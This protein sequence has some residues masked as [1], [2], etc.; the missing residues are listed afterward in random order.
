MANSYIPA[1][2]RI[3]R[4][5]LHCPVPTAIEVAVKC[6]SRYRVQRGPFKG[7]IFHSPTLPMLLGTY[8]METCQAI[9]H[10]RDFAVRRVINIGAAAGFYAIG[11]ARLFPNST[12]H[13]FEM[14]AG[15]AEMM[16]QNAARNSVQDRIISRG[17][18]TVMDL[19]QLTAPAGLSLVVIDVEG[20]E[21]DLL[22]PA[23]AP[24]LEESLVFVEL[25]DI[26]FEGCA[27]TIRARFSGTHEIHEFFTKDRNLGDF[28]FFWMTVPPLA[29]I[30]RYRRALLDCMGES[31]PGPQNWF[32]M[33]PKNVGG[34]RLSQ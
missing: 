28:P 23:K 34:G 6:L 20:A 1:L 9:D 25:H 27:K 31:R 7:M 29:W 15:F 33:I 14:E 10:I 30:P 5:L 17:T 13:A 4:G 32:L 12:I 21:L 8:E 19:A 3:A 24:G 11:F 2:S 18:C 26:H 16:H 22:D